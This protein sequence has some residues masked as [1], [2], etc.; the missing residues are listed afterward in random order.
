[1]E[2]CSLPEELYSAENES[3]LLKIIGSTPELRIVDFLMDNLTLDFTKKEI[4]ESI[5]MAKRTLYRALPKLEK[6]GVV[7]VSRK[8]G[9]AKLYKIN[10]ENLI[11]TYFR[12]IERE[13]S[14]REAIKAE[15]QERKELMA[16]A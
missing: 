1:M 6:E 5:G 11:I 12:K 10:D 2:E 8:I 7:K 4:M 3:L 16:V 13:L 14:L 15:E 9:K